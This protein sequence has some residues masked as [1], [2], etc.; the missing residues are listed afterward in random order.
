MPGHL[1][2]DPSNNDQVR[3]TGPNPDA[4][5]WVP[6][7]AEDV[8][9]ARNRQI[10]RWAG[11]VLL[12]LLAVWLVY[13]R[14]ADPQQARQSYDAGVRLFK[15]TKYQ[16]AIL[17]FDR[18]IDLDSGDIEAYRMRARAHLGEGDRDAAIADFTSVIKLV[19]KDAGALLERGTIYMEKKDYDKTIGDATQ[20]LAVDPKLSRAYN[21]RATATRAKGDVA[22]SLA[23]F[24]HA[25]ELDGNLD[26]YF[27]RAATYQMLNQHA[28]AIADLDR[29]LEFAPDQPPIYFARSRSKTASGDTAG[30]KVDFQRGRQLDGW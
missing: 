4:P 10:L 8:E 26:N 12:V 20:A 11:I 9:R 23:D 1:K 18:T 21:L 3:N 19:H 7:T 29:V 5:K 2:N 22:G 30:A 13:K 25:V 28:L 6:V 24:T 27:Q 16:Q 17:N 15:G 14:T